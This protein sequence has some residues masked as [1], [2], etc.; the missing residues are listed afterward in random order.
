MKIISLF[1]IM[2]S[3]FSLFGIVSCTSEKPPES[4]QHDPAEIT[5]GERLFL[6]TRFAQAYFAKPNS[7]DPSLQYTLTMNDPLPGTFAG[8]T[9]NCRVCH[10]VDEHLEDKTAGMRAYADFIHNSPIPNR[11][12]G[13][14]ATPRNSMSLVNINIA[15]QHGVLFH[16]DGE[17]NS[18]EDL[19]RATL[20]GRNYG[21]L[22][23]ESAQAIKHIANII[24]KDDG[25]DALGQEF[26]GRYQRILTATDATIPAEFLLP[27]NY[28]V[29]VANASDQ[30]IFN[31][32]AKLISVYVN[33]L[34][35]ARDDNGNYI[36][37]PYDH[38]LKINN[39][40]RQPVKG[41][42]TQQYASRLLTEIN[43]LKSPQYVTA[44]INT[45]K[46]H[47]Q[48]FSFGEREFNGMKLFFRQGNKN[49]TGG[50]CVSCHSAPHF[51]DF[52]FHNTG[53]TELNY[54]ETHGAGTFSKLS[55]PDLDSRNKNY[56][57]YLP[58]TA[59]HPNASDRF[60]TLVNIDKPGYTDL[61]MWNVFANPDIPTP[62]AK[63][64][65][66]MCEQTK[67][68]P[69]TNE[70]LLPHTVGTFKTP[71][72]RD[73]GHSDPYMHSGQF[74]T[75]E[76]SVTLYLRSSVLAKKNKLRNADPELNKINITA[77]EVNDLVAFLKALNE[78]YD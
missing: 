37:S 78:D 45:F 76:E 43:K 65:N 5:V 39:L 36:G 60:R 63:L 61:G 26:G 33:D 74:N 71:V 28:R 22:A 17:F 19:V 35:F 11:K 14:H 1:T 44:K 20:S 18:M 58:A 56:N 40:P 66:L 75:L 47:K 50:N 51:S 70:A 68:T 48:I 16:F 31:A 32:V 55:I 13:L 54:D 49:N 21:W 46:Y 41:E 57:Q 8:K 27:E 67:V 53:L 64:K 77:N 10:M 73:L 52:K 4:D 9:I 25:M 30:Q 2:V 38:F 7:A 69:C 15:S 62:Q 12:D 42:S 6:E 24:R 29:D 3:I 59:K 72:L 23:D 34:S